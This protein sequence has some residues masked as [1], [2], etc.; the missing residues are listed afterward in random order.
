[1][2][3]L[4]GIKKAQN[5]FAGLPQPHAQKKEQ[6]FFSN[7]LLPILVQPALTS[8]NLE[9]LLNMPGFR[10]VLFLCYG[11]GNF[12]EG[13]KF[14]KQIKKALDKGLGIFF[15]SQCPKGEA[16][17]GAYHAGF[18]TLDD[19]IVNLRDMTLEAA[20]TKLMWASALYPHFTDLSFVMGKNLRGEISET[21][22]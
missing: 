21:S 7:D 9:I 8:Q 17:S 22:P 18:Q 12:P 13:E 10:S 3:I 2:K 1:M 14:L 6:G 4:E 19:R 20:L 5:S 11:S 15:I 16:L